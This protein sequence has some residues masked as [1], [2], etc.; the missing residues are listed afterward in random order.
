MN[1]PSLIERQR[2]RFKA[3]VPKPRFVC[4]RPVVVQELDTETSVVSEKLE[5]KTVDRREEMRPYKCSDFSLHNLVA[6]GAPL[7]DVIMHR[8]S[9]QTADG[10]L[11]TLS[12]LPDSAFGDTNNDDVE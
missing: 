6:I 9:L 10:L 3:V 12:N 1:I 2:T 8:S 7:N 11:N 4:T 5:L